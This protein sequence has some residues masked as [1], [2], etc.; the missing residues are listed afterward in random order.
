MLLTSVLAALKFAPAVLSVGRAA[1]N[2]LVDDDSKLPDSAGEDDVAAAIE[3]L[4]PEQRD[5]VIEKVLKT[6][7][8]LQALDTQRFLSMNDGDAEKLRAS[9][10]P[11]IA[12]RAMKVIET[13]VSVFKVVFF[14]TIAEW[15][16][17]AG[18]AL[19]GK[20]FPVTDSVWSLFAEEEPVTV[21]IWPQVV[22]AIGASVM[23]ILKYMGCRERDKA[24]QFE[25]QAGRPLQ[26]AEAVATAAGG[27]IGAIV[28]AVRGR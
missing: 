28:K 23:V 15:L 24:Q 6:K 5:A 22:T 7:A 27:A 14:F 4:P 13:V 16:G 19:A 2:A 18:F 9:A 17:R 3:S 8:R 21:L 12:L 10:R 20:P 11:E 1:Y 26:S 25:L